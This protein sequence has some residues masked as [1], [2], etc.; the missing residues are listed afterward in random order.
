MAI[1][2][3]PSSRAFLPLGARLAA[4]SASSGA[5]EA[6]RPQGSPRA[7]RRVTQRPDVARRGRTWDELGACGEGC[8]EAWLRW[9]DGYCRTFLDG[10]S[11]GLRVFGR[12]VLGK[13]EVEM[14]KEEGMLS[15]SVVFEVSSE[16]LTQES[17]IQEEEF[18]IHTPSI[19]RYPQSATQ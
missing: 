17:E 4:P 15:G 3:A 5:G 6:L 13:V 19:S 12:L 2:P 16:R 9:L 1:H 11:F 8:G 14:L 10:N 18:T 7:T